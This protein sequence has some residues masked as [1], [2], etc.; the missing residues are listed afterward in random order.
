VLPSRIEGSRRDTPM[1]ARDFAGHTIDF[2]AEQVMNRDYAQQTG[3]RMPGIGLAQWT[4][5]NRRENLF[6]HEF[7]GRILGADILFNMD[8]QVDYLVQEMQG[9]YTGVY[10]TITNAGVSLN[11]AS[12]EVVYRFEVPGSVLGD[13]GLLPRTDP[14]VQHVFNQRRR[15][16]S[17]A[18]DVY[19]Q[20]QDDR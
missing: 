5:E 3:P 2:S 15:N 13:N 7:Q 11:D 6:L 10:N 14:D 9:S 19:Q 8:A 18:L 17:R 16:G 4:S 20:A 1:R 12:D